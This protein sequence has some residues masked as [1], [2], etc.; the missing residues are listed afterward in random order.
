MVDYSE[1]LA[2]EDSQGKA[3]VAGAQPAL[4]EQFGIRGLYGYRTISLSS[5]YAATILIAKNGTGKTTL[6]GALDAFLKLQLYRLRNLEF[7][8]IFCH[9]KGVRQELILTREDLD[10]F[11]QMPTDTEF[12]R[13]ASRSGLEPQKLFQFLLS[14]Y[15]AAFENWDYDTGTVSDLMQAFSH[16][17]RAAE[18]ACDEVYASLFKRNERLEELRSGISRALADHEIVYLPTYRRV[19]LALTDEGEDARRRGRKKPKV[20]FTS[21]GL[22]TPEIQFGLESVREV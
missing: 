15:K 10:S 1:A 17:Q 22:H 16:N 4:I 19:E 9:L 20:S 3:A 13:L 7:S 8:E 6:L 12:I 5:K 14:D 11:M 2:S 21:S 18:H